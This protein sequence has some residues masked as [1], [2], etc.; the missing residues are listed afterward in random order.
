MALRKLQHTQVPVWI[1]LRHLPVELWTDEGL[2]T[3]AS[4]VGKPLYPDTITRACTRLDFARV[5]I[6][7]DITSKLPKHIVIMVPHEESGES[8]CKV[9][10]EYEWL[11]PKC[12]TCMSLGHSTAGCPTVKPCQSP[13]HVYVP[14]PVPHT[15]RETRT[16]EGERQ[17]SREPRPERVDG[18]GGTDG[19]NLE[20]VRHVDKGKEFVLYNAFDMLNELDNDGAAMESPISSLLLNLMINAAIWNVRG[21]N[22]RDHQV[23]VT[24]L[25]SEHGLHFIGL[26][27]T[28]VAAGNVACVQ[29]GLLPHWNYYVDYG[30]PGNRVWLSWDPNFVDVTVVETGVQFVH[31]SVCIRSLHLSVFI[32]VV[33]GVNDT[34][35]RR[36]LWNELS[37]ISTVVAG[38]PWLVGGDFNTVLDDS[39]VCGQSGDI[40]GLPMNFGTV[41]R[42]RVSYTCLCVRQRKGDLSTNVSLAKSF[43]DSA[44][45]MLAT[46]RH[47]PTLLHLAL[48]CKLVL[49]LA[50]SLE[51]NM[52]HQRAKMAWMKDGDQCSRIFFRKV[53]KRRASKRVFQINTTDGRTLTSQPAVTNE[54]VRYYQELLGGSTRDRL[55]DLRY[56]RPW[57]RHIL[58]EEEAESL[59]LPVSPEEV[60]QAIFDID[61]TKA[62]GPDGYS[63]GFY[64]AAWPVI[65]GEVTQAILE[66]FRTGRL[67]KQ[68]NSTL[69]SLIPKVSNPTIVAEFRPIS[70][71]N[72]LY[73]AITKILVQRMRSILDSLISPSQNAFVPGRSIGDNVMLAQELFSGYNQR[74]LPPRC[75]LKVDLRK[76]YDTVEW[77]FL[78]AVLTLFGFPERFIIWIIECVTTPSFSVYWAMGF[79]LPKHIIKEIEKRLRNFLWSGSLE[80]GYAKFPSGPR[81]TS[82]PISAPLSTVIWEESWTWP[83]ITD[84]ESVDITHDLP[85]IHGGQDRILWTGPR[86]SFSSAAAY[87]VFC[88]PGPTVDWSSLL[89]GTFHIPRHRFILWLAIQGRLSTKDKPWLQH[90]GSACVLYQV[91]LPES[92]EHLFFMCTF[93]SE[94]IHAIRREVFF[95]WPYNTWATIVRWAVRWRGKH[96]VNASYRALLASMVYHLW[97]ERNLRV[98]Q[99]TSRTTA[100]IAR[101]VVSEI[102]DLII[103]KQLPRTVSTRG[104]YRLWRIP[105][106][107]EGEAH[108]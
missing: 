20:T 23:S 62:P 94:C 95:H 88:P 106:P 38:T 96:V 52:L 12:T 13:V 69:I 61:E 46:E 76:A 92:H 2:S 28:R 56:L 5:C 25:I 65:G 21:L 73:K 39:E 66:F 84:M 51:Q 90:L 32:T 50:S 58:T 97:R 53:A 42:L 37:R 44:Q 91:D 98:F 47:C 79:I 108:T 85:T 33:Y 77:D 4:G 34:V 63:A 82:I 101:I 1:K 43:L 83:P 26:L 60:K 99:H 67:L 15:H 102:R 45:T 74:H 41:C 27:E 9:D 8:P 86:G 105:W 68:V 78:R 70:C 64:K 17:A 40:R 19:G 31:C 93:A 10:V 11:P 75:A 55:I 3:V 100:E 14:K 18:G 6:M 72:V 104:L 59:I 107:V 35:G 80:M 103:C 24:D 29:R 16:N 49:R 48:C 81:H 36:E 57:E 22:R 30:G 87:D 89:V 54:F 7:F 71:C